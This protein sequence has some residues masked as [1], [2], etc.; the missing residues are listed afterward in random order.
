M[1]EAFECHDTGFGEVDLAA[2]MSAPEEL[3]L[4]VLQRLVWQFGDHGLAR[5]AA[6]E[7]VS[8]WL[9]RGTGR[10]RTVSGCRIVRRKHQLVLGR[11]AGRIGR[12]P[13]ALQGP[14][15]GWSAVWD[16][17]FKVIV[18]GAKAGDELSLAAFCTVSAAKKHKLD[19]EKGQIPAFVRD[20]LPVLLDRGEVHSVPHLGIC[21]VNMNTRLSVDVRF[22]TN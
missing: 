17:R 19:R 21:G 8:E 4:R 6:L 18:H 11:E 12:A 13:V 14:V 20:G 9:E 1:Q 10:A 3:R 5:M 22:M 2:F 7:R 15:E 16:R